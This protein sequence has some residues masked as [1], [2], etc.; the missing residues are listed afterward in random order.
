M[1]SY[2]YINGTFIYAMDK[3]IVSAVALYKSSKY[4]Q[5]VLACIGGGTMTPSEIAESVGIRLNHVSMV[6][7]KLKASGLVKCLNEDSKRGRLYELTA[8]GK[9]VIAYANKHSA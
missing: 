7:A 1:Y 9:Q 4:R 2:Y 6:L 8:L 3:R 5:K